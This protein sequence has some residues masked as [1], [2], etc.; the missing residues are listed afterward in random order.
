MPAP[1]TIAIVGRFEFPEGNAGAHRVAGLARA[2]QLAGETVVMIGCERDG[3]EGESIGSGWFEHEGILYLPV[4]SASLG[5]QPPSHSTIETF[6]GS[7]VLARLSLLDPST[8]RAVI[9]YNGFA[10]LWCRLLAFRRRFGVP[11]I[12]D[13]TEWYDSSHYRWRSRPA[14][15]VDSLL[16]MRFLHRRADAMIVISRWLAEHYSACGT[17]LAIVPPL[18]DFAEPKWASRP[19]KARRFGDP[20]ELVF[21]GTCGKKELLPTALRALARCVADGLT[22]WRLRVVGPSPEEVRECVGRDD[23]TLHCITDNLQVVG[24]VDHRSALDY[25]R[26]ADFSLVIREDRRFAKAGFP[27]KLAESFAAGTPVIATPIGEARHHVVDGRT[28]LVSADPSPDAVRAA[29]ARAIT[30][31]SES[32]CAMRCECEA[33]AR[34]EFDARHYSAALTGMVEAVARGRD[35]RR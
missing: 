24:R 33:Y 3:H 20:I 16:R 7:S 25:L 21:V 18:I 14:Y 31:A 13:V 28:G 34:R 29:L 5:G 12:A 23:A 2:L 30:S 19:P 8:L 32:V 35:V 17:P 11:L 9:V 26:A 15:W 22:S 4:S 6:L 27:S 10:G 1:P